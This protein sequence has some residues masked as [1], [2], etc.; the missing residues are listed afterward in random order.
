MICC[1]GQLKIGEMSGG[2]SLKGNEV[3]TS[4]VA[5]LPFHADFPVDY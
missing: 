2:K 1:S 5:V 3:E 4:Y